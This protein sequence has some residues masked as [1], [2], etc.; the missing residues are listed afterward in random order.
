MNTS[1]LSGEAISHAS[2]VNKTDRHTHAFFA[3]CLFFWS[4]TLAILG[5][6]LMETE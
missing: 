6:K 2:I 4:Q 5:G 3:F 1:G